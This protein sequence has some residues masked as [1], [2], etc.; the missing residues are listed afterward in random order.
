LHDPAY[1]DV[2]TGLLALRFLA[3]LGMLGC[4]AYGGWA[5]GD[6]VLVSLALAVG[7]PL[8][9][10]LVWGRWVAPRASH[11]LGDPRRMGVEVVLFTVAVLVLV[12]GDRGATW[13]GIVTWTAWLVSSPARGKEPVPD[14]DRGTP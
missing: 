9:A 5:L 8:A 13:F 11:R 14:R 12:A 6:D 1:A 7:L 4:L 2:V 10:A 3:E